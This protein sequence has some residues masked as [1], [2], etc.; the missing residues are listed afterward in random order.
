MS[1]VIDQQPSY[2]WPV[3]VEFPIDG[4]KFQRQT[5]DAEMKRLSQDRIGEIWELIKTEELN[6]RDL[7][8]EILLGWDGITDTK[9]DPVPFSEKARDQLLNVQLVA[10]AIVQAWID[11][12]GKRKR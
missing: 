4:G 10:S 1:F 2:R 3:P 9:G 8:R 6:D 11:S 5:F 12:L 7:C